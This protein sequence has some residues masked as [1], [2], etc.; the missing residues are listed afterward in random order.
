MLY[1][2]CN[3]TEVDPST[4]EEDTADMTWESG[5]GTGEA[6]RQEWIRGVLQSTSSADSGIEGLCYNSSRLK[7]AASIKDPNQYT[8]LLTLSE[9]DSG[10]YQ[11]LYIVK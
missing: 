6:V 8:P 1:N 5:Y 7:Y 4:N 3:Y 2:Y 10:P 11:S 9:K